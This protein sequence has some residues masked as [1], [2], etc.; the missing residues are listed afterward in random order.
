MNK[1]CL[2]S[3]NGPRAIGPY[4]IAIRAGQFV[5]CS[6][7]IPVDPKTGEVV[8]RTMSEQARQVLENLKTVLADNG[9]SLANVVKTTCFL[10]D[11]DA[12]AE[13]NEVYAE[14]F[15][16]SP[17]ARSTVGVDKLPKGVLVEVEAIALAD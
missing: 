13:F 11:L 17:P 9:M 6:G 2:E 12:F 3:P 7:V 16:E 5:F 15:T 10:A 8:G 14:Y 1:E 4:S